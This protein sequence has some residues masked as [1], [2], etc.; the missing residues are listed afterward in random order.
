M[1]KSYIYEIREQNGLFHEQIVFEL[2]PEGKGN[3][4]PIEK[5]R[6][7]N[8]AERV[9][10][11]QRILNRYGKEGWKFHSSIIFAGVVRIVFE[12]ESTVTRKK[13]ASG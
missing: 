11:F 8:N 9:A 2:D 6:M 7:L 13:P 10:M 5:G 12:K 4:N 1:P 3:I